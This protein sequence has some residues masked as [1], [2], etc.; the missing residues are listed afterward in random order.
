[1]K[2]YQRIEVWLLLLAGAGAAFWALQPRAGST[3]G[4]W[5][6][7]SA[8][9][10]DEAEGARRVTLRGATLERDYG[11]ARLDLDARVRNDGIHPLALTPPHARLLAGPDGEREVA[12]FFLSAERP[13]E[14]APQAASEVRLRYWLEAADLQGPL[15][16]EVEGEKLP[17]KS[18]APCDLEK[19]ENRKPVILRG[20]EW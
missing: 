11:N 4:S 19:F 5:E 13:P 10:A 6:H 9:A 12:P 1:M 16:L 3:A 17:V 2:F 15:L 7:D 20:V 8:R 18:A 14:V